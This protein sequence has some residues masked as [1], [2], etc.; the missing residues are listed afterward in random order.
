MEIEVRVYNTHPYIHSASQQCAVTTCVFN[1]DAKTERE[2]FGVITFL[3]CLI[4]PLELLELAVMEAV[5][6]Y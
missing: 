4:T 2:A 5:T 3:L 1:S 6:I